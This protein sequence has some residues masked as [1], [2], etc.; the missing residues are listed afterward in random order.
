MYHVD[1]VCG[2]SIE[3][4]ATILACA[5]CQRVIVIEWPACDNAL[6]RAAI[7]RGLKLWSQFES[8]ATG[9]IGEEQST[10]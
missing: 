8:A 5:H 2:Y 9:S 4:K 6:D 7:L 1:C 3:S 10:T